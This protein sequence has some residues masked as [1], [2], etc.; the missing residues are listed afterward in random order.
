MRELFMSGYGRSPTPNAL[1]ETHGLNFANLVEF[2]IATC[3][4]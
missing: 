2:S 1:G 4:I 3:N